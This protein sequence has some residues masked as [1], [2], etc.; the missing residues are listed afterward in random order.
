MTSTD[1]SDATPDVLITYEPLGRQATVTQANQSKIS[2]AYDSANLAPDTETIQYDIDRNSTYEFT[3]VL[4]RSRD[5]L[6]RDNGFQLKDGTTI[7][8]QA[9]YGYHATDGRL[10][11][12]IGGCDVSSPQTFTYAGLMGSRLDRV[13]VI[14]H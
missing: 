13:P 7:E 9:T 11:A 1:Y 12:V 3:R 5:S 10:S 8:N 14:E 6:N 4:D 2:H